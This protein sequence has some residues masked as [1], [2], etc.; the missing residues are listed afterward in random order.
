MKTGTSFQFMNCLL[1]VLCRVRLCVP[2][3]VWYS[4][5]VW[6]FCCLLLTSSALAYWSLEGNIKSNFWQTPEKG[7]FFIP[8]LN[9]DT[10]YQWPSGRSIGFDCSVNK[11]LHRGGTYY[12]AIEEEVK[13]L[14]EYGNRFVVYAKDVAP[15]LGYLSFG[16][17]Q[18]IDCSPLVLAS[19]EVTLY[20]LIKRN[21]FLASGS[22]G[23]F[24]WSTFMLQHWTDS[25]LLGGTFDYGFDE[26]KIS[27]QYYHNRNMAKLGSTSSTMK[28]DD[29]SVCLFSLNLP[30]SEYMALAGDFAVDY[31]DNYATWAKVDPS[32]GPSYGEEIMPV[33]K[34]KG[35]MYCAKFKVK[36][37]PFS[38]MSGEVLTRKTDENFAPFFRKARVVTLNHI[39]DDVLVGDNQKGWET[40][41]RYYWRT[42][43]F[44]AGYGQYSEVSPD[45]YLGSPKRIK[46]DLIIPERVTKWDVTWRAK[47]ELNVVF[48]QLY[49]KGTRTGAEYNSIEDVTSTI[50]IKVNL[51]SNTELSS[52]YRWDVFDEF[53]DKETVRY[54]SHVFDIQLKVN[55]SGINSEVVAGYVNTVPDRA[56]TQRY[57]PPQDGFMLSYSYRF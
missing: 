24:D 11:V 5:I 27:A 50:D 54:Y 21:G 44:F 7:S 14:N 56:Y 28:T 45:Y 33:K 12:A 34:R 53:Y 25:F 17:N 35:I 2:N 15:G 49:R 36:D 41:W 32:D 40:S 9:V 42:L 47:K 30:I 31:F 18:R 29:D 37:I 4:F 57:W 26:M 19:P 6:I 20:P 10:L 1:D 3:S 22:F 8:A 52:V 43:I 38:G 51:L 23:K 46:E 48:A 55:L 39:A 16:V 13:N